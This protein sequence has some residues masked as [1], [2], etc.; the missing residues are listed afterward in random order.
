[1]ILERWSLTEKDLPLFGGRP[2]A[3][4]AVL[5]PKGPADA[6]YPLVIALSGRGEARKVPSEG[7]LGWPRDYRLARA[8]ERLC[9]PPLR[10]EDFQ[11]LA[12]RG[13]IRAANE[14]LAKSPYRGV[15]VACPYTPDLELGG[16]PDPFSQA[17]LAEKQGPF[18]D[19]LVN[20]LVPFLRT[21]LPVVP[22]AAATGIDGVSLGGHLALRYG[23]AYPTAFGAVSGIQPAIQAHDATFWADQMVRARKANPALALRVMTSDHDYFKEAV[24]ALHR[25]LARSGTPHQF[26][27]VQGPHDYAFNRGPGSLA[28]LRFQSA[29]LA[30][31]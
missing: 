25:E 10:P 7:A 5:R 28:L 3:E 4:V 6:K 11:G 1:M 13:E 8:H 21:R 29:H 2:T 19:W 30:R 15:I 16:G 26:D 18:G 12:S 31:E 17:E 27:E 23:L 22:T 20:H 24:R 9:K 14:E